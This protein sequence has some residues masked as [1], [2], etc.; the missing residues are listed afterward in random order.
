MR[1]A[2]KSLLP[3]AKLTVVLGRADEVKAWA[4]V[5]DAGLNSREEAD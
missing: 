2:R 1:K 5:V 3:S 4:T